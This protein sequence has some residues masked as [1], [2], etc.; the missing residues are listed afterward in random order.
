MTPD[1]TEILENSIKT[2]EQLGQLSSFFDDQTILKI[3]LQTKVIH[4]LFEDNQDIDTNKLELFHVQFTDTL[5]A[6]L[7]KIKRRNER[8]VNMNKNEIEINNDMIRKIRQSML[9]EGGF[10]AERLKQAKRI[11][12]SVYELHKSLSSQSDEYPFTENLNAFGNK[13]YKEYFYDCDAKLLPQLVAFDKSN[14][15][16]N[17]FA[18]IDKKL[19]ITLANKLYNV[20]F[21]AGVRFDNIL[22]EIYK[23]QGEELYFFFLWT[24]RLFLFCDISVFPYKEWEAALSKKENLI[25]ELVSKNRELERSI[26]ENQKLIEADISVLLED[27]YKK[28]TDF[29]FLEDLENV[30]MQAN[31]LKSMLETKM[32]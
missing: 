12:K 5:I 8:I 20:T 19:L 10:D 30:D 16:R 21:F 22:M 11:G 28:I 13:F 9:E 31:I 4:K 29:D 7:D 14:V 6:L 1:Q 18:T 17:N 26:R 23:I 32:I 3:Y 15:Y 25:K 27:N 2:V 24:K